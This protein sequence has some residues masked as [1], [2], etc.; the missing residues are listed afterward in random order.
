MQKRL[1]KECTLKHPKMYEAKSLSIILLSKI[2]NLSLYIFFRKTY[3]LLVF[4]TLARGRDK[5]SLKE[6]VPRHLLRLGFYTAWVWAVR[7]FWILICQLS[8][9]RRTDLSK[10]SS[11]LIGSNI[12]PSSCIGGFPKHA[13]DGFV[14]DYFLH[15]HFGKTTNGNDIN[16][17]NGQRYPCTCSLE[18]FYPSDRGGV[19]VSR[20]IHGK[21]K[22]VTDERSK[23][24]ANEKRSID[25]GEGEGDS[26]IVHSYLLIISIT[27]HVDYE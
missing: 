19:A 17:R 5:G 12:D 18:D 16:K 8:Y 10:F 13:T 14:C 21:T 27:P 7:I 22:S 25:R 23:I 20:G 15:R 1:E 11:N 6:H 4:S 9:Q 2:W 26:C 24:K 3:R